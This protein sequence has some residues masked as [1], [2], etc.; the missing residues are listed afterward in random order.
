MYKTEDKMGKAR[1]IYQKS[2]KEG[3]HGLQDRDE[4]VHVWYTLK[5]YD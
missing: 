3:R 1:Q 5:G 4:K 2:R